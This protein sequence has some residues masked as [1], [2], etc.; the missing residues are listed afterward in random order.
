MTEK[1]SEWIVCASCGIKN[2]TLEQQSSDYDMTHS[3]SSL[4][5]PSFIRDWSLFD[6]LSSCAATDHSNIHLLFSNNAIGSEP[7]RTQNMP[8][9]FFICTTGSLV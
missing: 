6:G 5:L 8:G 1:G 9:Y 4:L 3:V 7:V 2:S